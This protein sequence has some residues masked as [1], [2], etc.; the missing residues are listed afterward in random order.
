VVRD[1]VCLFAR[2]CVCVC[3]RV[4]VC[5]YVCVCARVLEFVSVCVCAPVH[6]IAAA[7]ALLLHE[8]MLTSLSELLSLRNFKQ[9]ILYRP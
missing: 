1:S 7:A 2:A 6:V 5:V 9:Y 8:S 4:C 3:A